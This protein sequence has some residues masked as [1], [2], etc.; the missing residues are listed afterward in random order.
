MNYI[1]DKLDNWLFDKPEKPRLDQWLWKYGTTSDMA[2]LR[3]DNADMIF[4]EGDLT[5][6]NG[7]DEN[8]L[9]IKSTHHSL[10]LLKLNWI[11][12]AI[13]KLQRINWN[14]KSLKRKALPGL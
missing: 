5:R 6:A 4:R 12:R 9:V 2:W 10:A 8:H 11:G 13:V 14:V 3:V 7:L 1:T